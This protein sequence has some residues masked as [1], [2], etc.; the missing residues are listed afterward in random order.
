MLAGRI[1][2]HINPQ[3][4]PHSRARSQAVHT[5]TSIWV[6]NVNSSERA[7]SVNRAGD[8]RVVA[9]PIVNNTG[10]R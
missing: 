4:A 1:W 10:T 2:K 7:A 8:V 9:T 5:R 3:T 6:P